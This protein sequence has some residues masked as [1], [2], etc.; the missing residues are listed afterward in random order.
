MPIPT[1]TQQVTPSVFDHLP[2]SAFAREADLV[3]SPSRPCN[4]APLPFSAATLWRR[5]KDGTFPAPVKLG[6]RVTAWRVSD[7]RAWMGEVA[8]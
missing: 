7:V 1:K 8:Q 5:V 2:D 3:R 4:T 6:A